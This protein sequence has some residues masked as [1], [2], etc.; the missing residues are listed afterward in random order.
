MENRKKG[1]FGSI[2]AKIMIGGGIVVVAALLLVSLKVID[3][4][5]DDGEGA[6][7]VAK[8][9]RAEQVSDAD[10][11]TKDPE[12][13][14]LLQNDEFIKLVQDKKFQKLIQNKEFQNMFGY[15]KAAPRDDETVQPLLRSGSFSDAFAFAKSNG[16]FA[17][18][19]KDNA[20][21]FNRVAEFKRGLDNSIAYANREGL[22]KGDAAEARNL[23]LSMPEAFA[24]AKRNGIYGRLLEDNALDF[25]KAIEFKRGLDDA[26]AFASREGLL[27]GDAAEEFRGL[28]QNMPEALSFAK[29]NGIYGRLLEDNALDF[30][31]AIEFKR[32]LDEAIAYANQR[33]LLT[34]SQAE[35]KALSSGVP[36]AIA[37]ARTNAEFADVLA[38]KGL[39]FNEVAEFKSSLDDLIA[40]ANNRGLLKDNAEEFKALAFTMPEAFAFAKSNGVFARYLT[41]NALDFN[42]VVE[43]KRGLDEAIAYASSQ[44]IATQ[45]LTAVRSLAFSAPEAMAFAI[46]NG[47]LI[48]SA[49]FGELM[50]YSAFNDAVN[51]LGF[52]TLMTHRDAVEALSHGNIAALTPV[53]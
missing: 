17:K 26:I 3:F 50:G 15:A 42:K 29:R 7:G 38:E 31:K 53:D 1:P 34:G 52:A 14:A 9:Y 6:I 41:D 24:F 5:A 36:D 39:D 35:M 25:N 51:S 19:L 11:I 45:D 21:D 4:P 28:A 44:G 49:D 20:L 2:T 13:Q 18:Y 33:G 40:Y 48:G 16:V 23:A 47:D 30:N 27:S 8:K 22:A 43:F 32:S 12:I 10:V 46:S 37:Y